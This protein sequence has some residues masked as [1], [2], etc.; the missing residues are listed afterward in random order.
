VE[1]YA[2]GYNDKWDAYLSVQGFTTGGL[3]DKY[4]RWKNE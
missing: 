4:T 3:Q 2:G 1:G